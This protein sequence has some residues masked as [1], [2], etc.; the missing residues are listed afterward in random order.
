[1]LEEPP[2]VGPPSLDAGFLSGLPEGEPATVPPPG[3]W[4]RCDWRTRG[5]EPCF[6]CSAA[7]RIDVDEDAVLA[8]PGLQLVG[9]AVVALLVK[10]MDR[11][12][13]RPITNDW[14]PLFRMSAVRFL[15]FLAPTMN[16]IALATNPC[17]PVEAG[18]EQHRHR[19][20]DVGP[21]RQVSA[22]VEK[23]F[24]APRG[25][26]RRTGRPR[27]GTTGVRGSSRASS[28]ARRAC[29]TGSTRAHPLENHD[30]VLAGVGIHEV[31]QQGLEWAKAVSL[32]PRCRSRVFDEGIRRVGQLG[33][34]VG[35][36]HL[37]VVAPVGQHELVR[38]EPLVHH[39][40]RGGS[41]TGTRSAPLSR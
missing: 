20:L 30:L 28:V 3:A 14:N 2:P 34:L 37:P 1:M 31:D 22:P 41:W 23:A 29:S 13:R 8:L 4:A 24:R 5:S 16:S 18:D 12:Q 38:A 39:L 6:G 32:T 26:P 35:R 27:P 33:S 15:Q 9:E 17:P 36:L 11:G 19:H 40:L 21:A 7:V 10:L 25:A